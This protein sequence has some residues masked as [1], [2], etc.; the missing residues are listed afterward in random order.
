MMT[1]GRLYE[2]HHSYMCVSK[3]KVKKDNSF[4]VTGTS[5]DVATGVQINELYV[6]KV[7]VISSIVMSMHILISDPSTNSRK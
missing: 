7:E 4:F 1:L 2:Q 3:C 5:T 6:Y